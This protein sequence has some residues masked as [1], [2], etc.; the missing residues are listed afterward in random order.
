[1]TEPNLNP[2]TFYRAAHSSE[3]S[4]LALRGLTIVVGVA[5]LTASAKFS[6]PFYPVPLTLQPLVVLLLGAV[7]GARL[8]GSAVLAYLGVG[9]VGLPVFA[10]TPSNGIGLAYMLG[11]TGGFLC[12]FLLAAWLV[13]TLTVDAKDRNIAWILMTMVAGMAAIYIPG[14]LWLGT[15]VGWD[16]PILQL[17]F[18]P[19][20]YGDLLKIG[21]AAL[22]VP[23]VWRLQLSLGIDSDR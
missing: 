23:G 20:I 4:K 9:A 7:L 16:K 18:Y 2:A 8:G 5:A 21:I 12:G 15:V 13:G 6:T 10:G 11:P 17:G 1:M 14:I 22:L 19:F 3:L